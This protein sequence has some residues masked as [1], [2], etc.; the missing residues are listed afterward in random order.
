LFKD[1]P[2]LVNQSGPQLAHRAGALK[3]KALEQDP[4]G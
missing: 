4:D 2:W 1:E 3:S